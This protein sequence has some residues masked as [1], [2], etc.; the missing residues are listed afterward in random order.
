MHFE[1][2]VVHSDSRSGPRAFRNEKFLTRLIKPTAA[3][4]FA[5]LPPDIQILEF[6]PSDL[7]FQ[8]CV[9]LRDIRDHFAELN[10]VAA[11]GDRLQKTAR[12]H[13]DDK[14]IYCANVG[15]GNEL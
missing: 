3:T 6:S 2:H 12:Q 10:E 11:N 5:S 15:F 8:T 7:A 4:T 13:I 9:H 1:P 14:S